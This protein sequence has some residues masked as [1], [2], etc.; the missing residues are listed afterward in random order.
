MFNPLVDSFNNISTTDLE[1]KIVDLQRKYF[2]TSNP[3]VHQQMSAILDMYI[4]EARSRRATSMKKDMEDPE[5]GLDKL[6]NIS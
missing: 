6:I 3:Q 1:A 2:M 4:T 5:S